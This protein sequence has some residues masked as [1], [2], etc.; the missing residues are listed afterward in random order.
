MQTHCSLFF[1]FVA[2]SFV[3]FLPFGKQLHKVYQV[4]IVTPARPHRETHVE[5][6]RRNLV[7]SSLVPEQSDSP[8]EQCGSVKPL[9]TING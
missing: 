6:R 5:T 2:A 9:Q 4:I 3:C 7:Y 8:A 1:S